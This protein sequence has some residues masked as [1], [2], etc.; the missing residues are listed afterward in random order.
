MSNNKTE[1]VFYTMLTLT[2]NFFYWRKPVLYKNHCLEPMRE[3]PLIINQKCLL[4]KYMPFEWLLKITHF[5]YETRH[6]Y[7]NYHNQLL[8]KN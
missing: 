5:A 3:V 4:L 6:M 2:K 1:N 8:N 7:F